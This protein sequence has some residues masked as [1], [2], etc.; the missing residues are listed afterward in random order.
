[1]LVLT[2]ESTPE[3]GNAF[4]SYKTGRANT[5]TWLNTIGQ[6]GIS[7]NG[8]M[9]TN[10]WDIGLDITATLYIMGQGQHTTATTLRGDTPTRI[11]PF[12]GP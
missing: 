9:D 7:V 8:T 6:N 4:I 10:T 3:R 11:I 2:T 5:F 12:L 1:M